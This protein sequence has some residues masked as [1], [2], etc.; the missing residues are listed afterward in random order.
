VVSALFFTYILVRASFSE[1]TYL[2][3]QDFYMVLA[4][5]IV[6]LL[7]IFYIWEP[8][9]RMV[10]IWA[11]FILVIFEVLFA[12]RQFV[13]GDNWMPFGFIRA[14]SGHRASG[15]LISSIHLAGYLEVVGLFALS[16]ALWSASKI[17]PASLP[18][19]SLFFAIMA[20]RSPGAAA[21]I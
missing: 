1:V 16:Y 4:C 9:R 12:T 11:L 7:T 14:D 20:S 17:W 21:V 8:R 19:T 18:A 13:H 5:L 10:V 6:Y 15:T 3:W 2:W